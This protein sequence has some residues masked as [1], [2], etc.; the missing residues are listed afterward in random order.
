M[1]NLLHKLPYTQSCSTF[2]EVHQRPQSVHLHE[3]RLSLNMHHI[4]SLR[5]HIDSVFLNPERE[6]D[7]ITNN[8]QSLKKY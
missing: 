3:R 2:A 1:I 4:H 7:T 5:H 8:Y 6:T